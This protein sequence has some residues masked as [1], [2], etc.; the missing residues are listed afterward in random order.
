MFFFCS[1]GPLP[2]RL[3]EDGSLARMVQQRYAGWDQGFGASLEKGELSL[4]DCAEFV[5]KEGEPIIESAQ[6][7]RYQCVFNNVLYK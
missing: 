2:P 3:I 4:E 7:E 6:E 5:A 1:R